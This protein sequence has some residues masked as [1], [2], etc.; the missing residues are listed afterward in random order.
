MKSSFQ[1]NIKKGGIKLYYGK[2]MGQYSE[3]KRFKVRIVQH[4]MDIEFL[5]ANNIIK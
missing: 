4:I 2:V 3:L 1:L 5:Q